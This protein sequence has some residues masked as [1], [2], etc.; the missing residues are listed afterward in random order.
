[1][2]SIFMRNFL[3]MAGIVLLSLSIFC[4]AFASLSYNM[5][6]NDK[7]ETLKA[8]ASIVSITASAKATEYD[9]SDWDMRMTISSIAQASAV[10]IT[11]C[12]NNGVVVSCSDEELM[13]PR[14]GKIL[15]E[16]VLATIDRYGKYSAKTDLNGYYDSIQYIAGMAVLSPFTSD[17]L[18]YVL[19]SARA[20]E[21]VMIWRAFATMFF[22]VACG[23]MLISL[24]A[25]LVL[26]G[27][28]AA[29]IR[30][31]AEVA[32]KFSSGDF[33]ARV[34]AR[35]DDEMGELIESFNH[36]SDSIA[37]SENL[38]REFIANVSHELKT[39][40]TAIAGFADGLLDG[41]IPPDQRDRYL[42]IISDETRR[43][44]RLVRRMLEITRMQSIDPKS[45]AASSF[46]LTEVARKVI[47]SH[48]AKITQKSIEV[49][50]LVPEEP[51]FVKGE[52]DDITQVLYNIVDNA[53]KFSD[54]GG[55][56]RL[57][58]WKK[59]D[60]A[61]VS[62][63]NTGEGIPEDELPYIFE[64]FHKTDRSRSKDR[65]G[66][67]LGL[68]IVKSIISGYGEDIYVKSRDR[69]TEFVFTLTLRDSSRLKD[70]EGKRLKS[71]ETKENENNI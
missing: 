61:Y 58:I 44:S 19:V 3:V 33:S 7:K 13:S 65:E 9:L 2:K 30:E 55:K 57:S 53:V 39:P 68:Y 8:T 48:E 11:I 27:K 43:L 52:E 67:G 70:H 4:I 31:M 26:T 21:M 71:S 37:R 22:A 35:R 49:E 42:R 60:K 6:L 36:M 69:Q 10:H 41:T 47:L 1:M 24:I 16:H 29:P 14:L 38:R 45:L 18:G 64:R 40:M 17:T 66:V 20:N 56:L 12:D 54:R 28:H 23:V 15:P 5:V 32:R 50:L 34:R 63:I 62:T 25:S 46:E 51:L 59:G